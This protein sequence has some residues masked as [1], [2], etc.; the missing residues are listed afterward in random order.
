MI[1][2][3][4]WG[5]LFGLLAV[6]YLD[7][8]F[9]YLAFGQLESVAIDICLFASVYS[10]VELARQISN[11]SD[12]RFVGPRDLYVWSVRT[13]VAVFCL[14]TLVI[15]HRLL[16]DLLDRRI[17]IKFARRLELPSSL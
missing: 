13:S 4:S 12:P 17:A 11:Y 14:L 15:A 3:V 16:R 5:L 9:R 10:V 7:L 2:H 6:V 1:I 8:G